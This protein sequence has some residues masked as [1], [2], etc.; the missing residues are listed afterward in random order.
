MS[1]MTK[2]KHTEK[3]TSKS[4]QA[5]SALTKAI[6]A[7]PVLR[8]YTHQAAFFFFLGAGILLVADAHTYVS[9]LA[10]IVYVCS[11]NCLFGVSA[12][13]HRPYW[14]P[15]A[16]KW[17]RK[18]DHSSIYVLIAGSAT[19][20]LVLGLQDGQCQKVLLIVWTIAALGILKS[21]FWTEAPKYVN[22]FLY[23]FASGLVLPYFSSVK[24]IFNTSE[25]YL[26]VTGGICYTLGAIIYFLRRPDPFPRIFGYHEVFHALVVIG[27][28]LH[29]ILIYALVGSF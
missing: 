22:V 21:L 10:A 4:S 13:Y 6:L 20:M 2:E 28:S 26:L 12:L 15:D 19:P 24:F 8:G 9:R 17:L 23:L 7:K 18:L 5:K 16:R 3:P 29:F 25:V 27:S 11:L 14:G 1:F